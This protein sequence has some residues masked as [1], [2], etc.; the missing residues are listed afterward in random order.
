MLIDLI[1]AAFD[2]KKGV[3]EGAFDKLEG[4]TKIAI[5]LSGIAIL[6]ATLVLVFS[7][8]MKG[9]PEIVKLFYA[10]ICCIPCGILAVSL[11][12]RYTTKGFERRD[13]KHICFDAIVAS[14]FSVGSIVLMYIY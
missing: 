7:E 1:F 10:A 8:T 14:V 13:I 4:K 5:L 12:I 9:L 2:I 11:F 3:K 6:I